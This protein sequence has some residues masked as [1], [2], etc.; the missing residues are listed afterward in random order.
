MPTTSSKRVREPGAAKL[1]PRRSPGRRPEARPATFQSRLYWPTWA[2][3]AIV[4]L[5]ILFVLPLYTVLAIAFG[6]VDFLQNPLPVWEP[7]F[8]TAHYLTGVA[9]QIVGPGSYLGPV[10]IR[11]F[12]YVGLATLI[13]FYVAYPVAYHIARCKGRRKKAFLVLLLI[14][15]WISYLMRMLAWIGLLQ[16]DGYV[17]RVL[18]FLHLVP[19]RVG[20]LQGRPITVILGLVYGNIPYMIL[21][22]YGFLDRIDQH[23]LEAAKDLGA[24]PFRSFL[25]VTLP[26]SKPAILAGGVIVTLPMFGDYYTNVMLSGSPHTTMIGNVLDNAVENTGQGPYAAVFVLILM[27]LLLLP[28]AYYLRST[29]RTM[30]AR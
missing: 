29:R 30:E 21:P 23:L 15:F 6:T 11:T 22:L 1:T 16:N 8:W 7:W 4:W 12:V 10:Y 9:H 27:L 5:A 3:P 18:L 19:H 28:L 25:R 26:L 2:A 13:C 24:S 14:P 17:N 20:W